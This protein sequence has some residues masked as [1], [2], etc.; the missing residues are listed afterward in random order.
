VAATRWPL[1]H[2]VSSSQSQF[3]EVPLSSGYQKNKYGHP[4]RK[5]ICHL[6]AHGY[7]QNSIVSRLNHPALILIFLCSALVFLSVILRTLCLIV[8]LINQHLPL[9]KIGQAI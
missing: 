7:K 2:K 1:L 8:A 4:C 9:T 3:L 6:G 5:I